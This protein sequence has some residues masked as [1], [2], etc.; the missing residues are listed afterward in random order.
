MKILLQNHIQQAQ[1]QQQQKDA[2]AMLSTALD[3]IKDQLECCYSDLSMDTAVLEEAKSIVGKSE[4]EIIQMKKK[5][6]FLDT[7]VD[8]YF[9]EPYEE[10]LAH[11][12]HRVDDDNKWHAEIKATLV[13]F[14]DLLNP[15]KDFLNAILQK[16]RDQ[17]SEMIQ[18]QKQY[19]PGTLEK[20]QNWCSLLEKSQQQNFQGFTDIE[21]K[22]LLCG[23]ISHFLEDNYYPANNYDIMSSTNIQ[24]IIAQNQTTAVNLSTLVYNKQ[25]TLYIEPHLTR[26]AFN[27]VQDEYDRALLRITAFTDA[28]IA[29]RDYLTQKNVKEPFNPVQ[30]T[31]LR[32]FTNV[33]NYWYNKTYPYCKSKLVRK[34]EPMDEIIQI[35]QNV[36]QKFRL[37]EANRERFY[38]WERLDKLCQEAQ[39]TNKPDPIFNEY[40]YKV[41]FLEL[42]LQF[43]DSV[44]KI[45]DRITES[46]TAKKFSKLKDDQDFFD[47]VFIGQY[48]EDANPDNEIIYSIAANL[49]FQDHYYLRCYTKQNNR[50]DVLRQNIES[51]LHKYKL[52]APSSQLL[53]FAHGCIKKR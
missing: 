40:E 26:F 50:A 52:L 42:Y 48:L 37:A 35:M 49:N 31:A 23:P 22:D 9:S 36:V 47:W 12:E 7:L 41:A 46:F 34:Q 10:E 16:Y 29:T 39:E 24:K 6:K 3:S 32:N 13:K 18:T 25:K 53:E 33:V 11:W 1:Q 17:Y 2:V 27:P 45:F 20:I 19:Q 43:P 5:D 51:T 28:M 4:E 30:Q 21:K 8:D 14:Y 44:R 38:T 15:T